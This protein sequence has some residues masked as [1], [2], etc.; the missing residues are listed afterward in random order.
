[1]QQSLCFAASVGL[2]RKAMIMSFG[3]FRN[4][5]GLHLLGLQ[6]APFLSYKLEDSFGV[7]VI[8]HLR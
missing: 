6:P 8:T 2:Q 4:A 7:S 1:M 5:P 3:Q